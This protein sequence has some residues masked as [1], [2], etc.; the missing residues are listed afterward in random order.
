MKKRSRVLIRIKRTLI[1]LIFLAALGAVFY[2][3]YYQFQLPADQYG[4][5]FTKLNGW[6][7][8]VVK[9]ASFRIEWEGLIP[10]NL[11]M[12]KFDLLPVTKRISSSGTLPSSEIYSMYLENNP[13]FSFSYAFDNYIYCKTFQSSQFDN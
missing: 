8:L 11:K 1:T 2:F 6:D 5:I 12:E 9:P 10:L 4:V 3:G 7:P 13:D